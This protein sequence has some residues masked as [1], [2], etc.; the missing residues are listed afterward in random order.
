[1]GARARRSF[2]GG[3]PARLAGRLSEA[4]PGFGPPAPPRLAKAFRGRPRAPGKPQDPQSPARRRRPHGAHAAAHGAARSGGG[5]APRR[6]PPRAAPR[7]RRA[8][9]AGVCLSGRTATRCRGGAARQP[10]RALRRPRWPAAA[11]ARRGDRALCRHPVAAAARRAAGAGVCVLVGP[12]QHAGLHPGHHGGAVGAARRGAPGLRHCAAPPVPVG[13]ARQHGRARRRGRHAPR[14]GLHQRAHD[15][16]RH[17]AGA[18]GWVQ[19]GGSRRGGAV[20]SRAPQAS[21]LPCGARTQRRR[22][23]SRPSCP[24]PGAWI[25]FEHFT[26]FTAGA[27]GTRVDE[28]ATHTASFPGCASRG[29]RQ[30]GGQATSRGCS[31][32]FRLGEA[33]RPARGPTCSRAAHMQCKPA[34]GRLSS[35]APPILTFPSRAA[36]SASQELAATIARLGAEAHYGIWKGTA[37][38][39]EAPKAA[40][41]DARTAAPAG[42]AAAPTSRGAAGAPE[43]KSGAPLAAPGG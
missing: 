27:N 11:V 42:A 23:P 37:A 34:C 43:Q 3:R 26:N 31:G 4:P 29:G 16:A 38:A 33:R 40:V 35:W 41:P 6:A 36:R 20:A 17:R 8:A 22:R 7:I 32:L 10:S 15:G 12:Q 9:A 1:M 24:P 13:A 14:P 30:D 21:R 28:R 2:A 39:L 18:A 5:L 25:F 19:W